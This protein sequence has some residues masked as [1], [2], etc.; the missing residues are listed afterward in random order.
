MLMGCTKFNSKLPNLK[1]T[2]F[3]TGNILI[4]IWKPFHSYTFDFSEQHEESFYP[5]IGMTI[6]SLKA[7]GQHTKTDAS[8][9]S[10]TGNRFPV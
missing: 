1:D 5:Q 8:S 7:R 10:S 4:G 3:Q 6:M 2:F 9:R